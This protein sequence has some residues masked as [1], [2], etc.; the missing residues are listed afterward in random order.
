MSISYLNLDNKLNEEDF[1]LLWDIRPSIPNM[2]NMFGKLIE[3]PRR[4]KV[5]GKAYKFTGM[6]ENIVDDVPAILI[7]YLEYINTLDEFTYNSV[8]INWY[9]GEDYIGFHS[10]NE[11]NLQV[12]SNIYG[13]SFGQERVMRFK[14]IE[15]KK[16]IDYKL[17]NNSLIVM[18]YGCQQIYQ[19]SILKSKKLIKKRINITFRCIL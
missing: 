16:N 2:I 19:H 11:K 17:E 3:A 15:T 6:S 4:Y 8:L 14:N 7:P 10:D 5:Y 13:I 12:G 1:N 18:H 9:E